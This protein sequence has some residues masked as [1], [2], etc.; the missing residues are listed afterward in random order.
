MYMQSEE[1]VRLAKEAQ[2]KAEEKT[3]KLEVEREE[4]RAVVRDREKLVLQ[5]T[6]RCVCV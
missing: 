1:L 5:V 6:A 3:R 2:K 4:E